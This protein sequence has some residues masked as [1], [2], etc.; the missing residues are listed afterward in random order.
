MAAP[1]V[2][3]PASRVVIVGSQAHRRGTLS[4]DSNR[5]TAGASSNWYASYARSKLANILFAR[6]LQRRLREEGS[7]T[8]VFTVSPGRVNTQIFENLKPA[9]L[10]WG[11]KAFASLCMQTPAQGAS[12][13]LYA[14]CEPSLLGRGGAYLH[15]CREEAPS[16]AARDASL[17]RALWEV[18][19]GLLRGRELV[20]Q[21][22]P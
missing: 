11:A 6:E 22:R 2:L 19:E 9:P 3:A 8:D 14:A 18:T 12:T 7:S 1:S 17:A 20:G 4:I 21:Q 13:V 16:E 10:R 15:A 5:V